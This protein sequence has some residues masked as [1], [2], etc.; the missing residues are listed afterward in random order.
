MREGD[1]DQN[2]FFCCGSGFVWAA[3]PLTGGEACGRCPEA[4][5]GSLGGVRWLRAGGKG[6][7]R[8]E[9]IEGMGEGEERTDWIRLTGTSQA[10]K[11]LSHH[12]LETRRPK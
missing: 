3:R 10:P 12:G 6:A 7:T 11:A 2:H 8:E 9:E 1:R 4:G 5:I